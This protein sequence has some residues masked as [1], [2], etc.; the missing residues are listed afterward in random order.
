M[1]KMNRR[2][3]MKTT[4]AAGA[5]YWL[6]ASAISATRTADKPNGKIHVAGIGVG[7]KGS[8]DIDQAGNIGEVVALCDIDEGH[9]DAKAQRFQR[10]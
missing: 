4:A 8:S 2:N 9:L 1:S 10:G 6:T 5:G 3:F 7:G